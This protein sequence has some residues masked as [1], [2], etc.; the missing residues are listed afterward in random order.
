MP[1][2]PDPIERL[3]SVADR[4]IDAS[5]ARFNQQDE[6]IEQWIDVTSRRFQ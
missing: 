6:R 2:S 5:T 4:F 1:P 3:A